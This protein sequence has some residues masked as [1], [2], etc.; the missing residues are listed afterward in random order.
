MAGRACAVPG[1]TTRQRLAAPA[2]N[3]PPTTPPQPAAA[4]AA[5]DGDTDRPVPIAELR[6]R[7]NAVVEGH[8]RSVTVREVAGSPA[9]AVEVSGPM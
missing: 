9:L 7:R 1:G 6:W 3:Q 4:E 2:D 5:A 8:I